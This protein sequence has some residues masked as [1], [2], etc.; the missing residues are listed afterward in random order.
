MPGRNYMVVHF[1]RDHSMRV[2]RPDLS[3]PLGTP[4]AC[5]ES[6]CHADKPLAWVV[7]SYD[8][9]YGAKRK[10]HYG[11]VLAAA[12]EGRPDARN[13]VL[14]LAADR[15]R[16]AIVRATAIDLLW[17]YPGEESTK[18]LEQAM[19]DDDALI[20]RT[21]VNRFQDDDLAHFV[22]AIGPRLKD[23]VLG[24][25]AEA[26]SRLA[27]A[28]TDALSEPQ[29][30]AFRAALQEYRSTLAFSADMPSGR[31][32]WALLE[33][34]LGRP[35]EAEK[36]YRKAL[37]IDD[38]FYMSAAN[39]AIL[40]NRHGR[41]EEAEGLLQ[42][43]V[44]ANPRN[45]ASAFNLGLLL[46][47]MGKSDQAET[48]L[49]QALEADPSL[50]PAAYNLA[51]LVGERDP[52]RAA[53]LCRK[54]AELRPEEPKYALGRAY[55]EL[56]QGKD[57]DAAATLEALVGAHPAFKDAVLMLGDLYGRRGHSK[58]A[59]QLYDRALAAKGLSDRD[60]AEIVGR[61]RALP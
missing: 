9:W 57:S 49:R 48:A 32:N 16:P 55:Y 26:A 8:R 19:G 27:G 51:V 6:G 45:A 3:Q 36:Q 35:E 1:R 12:R 37:A 59:A 50:A 44:R 41:N 61:R 11:T 33:D 43:A 30:E 46:A 34:A 60:R 38:Q 39:L 52:A 7:A 47:E 29:K 15:L 28:P 58:Q 10:P 20:R 4:N 23:P 53:N 18:L 40:L 25:R 42:Q 24:V 54:A 14:A 31:H 5:S 22:K 21:A 13:D 2:P 56:Q 17:E